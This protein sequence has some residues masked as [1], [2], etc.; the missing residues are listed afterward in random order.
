ME[1]RILRVVKNLHTLDQGECVDS[2][3]GDKYEM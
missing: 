2:Q 3:R 1:V